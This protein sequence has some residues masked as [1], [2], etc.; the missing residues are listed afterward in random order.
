M[1]WPRCVPFTLIVS[2]PLTTT[3][4]SQ[5]TSASRKL[6]QPGKTERLRLR[7]WGRVCGALDLAVFATVVLRF[8]DELGVRAA[9][10][11]HEE[12]APCGRVIEGQW[13]CSLC[14]RHWEGGGCPVA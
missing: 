10:R 14:G 5:T 6:G 13:R 9:A 3:T 12:R 1:L 7:A 8:G 4:F 11:R 2:P